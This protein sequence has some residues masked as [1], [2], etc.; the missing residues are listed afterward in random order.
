[1]NTMQLD[2]IINNRLRSDRSGEELRSCSLCQRK[3]DPSDHFVIAKAYGNGKSLLET[4]QC[5]G[6]RM[7]PQEY[8]SE[9]SM[10]NIMLYSGRRFQEF[11]TDRLRR[12]LYFLEDPSCLITSEP[13]ASKESFELYTFNLPGSGLE[14]ESNYI[15]VGPTAMEQMS[16]LLSEETRREWGKYLETIAPDMPNLKISPVIF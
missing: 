9:Q 3:L 6:C 10:E 14:E 5:L 2:Q 7:E 13:I 16:E 15:M 4:V 8:A 1:M 12:K 11:L